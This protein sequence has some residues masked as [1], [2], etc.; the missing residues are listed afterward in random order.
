ME[1]LSLQ[2]LQFFLEED[3]FLLPEDAKKLKDQQPISDQT[4]S[5]EAPNHS[6]KEAEETYE[7]TP[8]NPELT[9]EDLPPIQVKGNFTKG[10]LIVHEED[11]L[12]E[13]VMNMLVKM[14]NAVGHSMNEVGLVSSSILE[15]RTLEEFE[16]LNAHIILKFGKI[17]HPVNS[18]PAIPYEVFTD[19]ET[20]YLFADALGQ[21]SEDNTMKRKLWNALQILFNIK[22]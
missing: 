15:N 10:L 12:S 7:S 22:K 14:I 3:L 5:L 1:N 2:E 17:K 8:S 20:Q 21:I 4:S 13:E 11:D 9:K 18:V 19:Q 16:A 6:V